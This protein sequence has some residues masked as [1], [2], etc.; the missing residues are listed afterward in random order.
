LN[1]PSA[2]KFADEARPRKKPIDAIYSEEQTI[3]DK[4]RDCC[5]R[6]HTRVLYRWTHF[7]MWNDRVRK[8]VKTRFGKKLDE[9]KVTF[10]LI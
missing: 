6:A 5:D 10:I 1:S 2:K 8:R 7:T 3:K 4:I 9:G